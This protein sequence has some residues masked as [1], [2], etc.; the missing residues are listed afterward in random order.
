[1]TELTMILPRPRVKLWVVALAVALWLTVTCVSLS[2]ETT[3]VPA[4]RPAL[5]MVMP[6]AI[7]TVEF[8]VTV[9]E[10]ATVSPFTKEPEVKVWLVCV[11]VLVLAWLRVTWVGLSTDTTVVPAGKLPLVSVIPGNKPTVE[12]IVTTFVPTLIEPPPNVGLP[13]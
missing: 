1:M 4:G 2:T 13:L 10:P 3:K 5:V 7:P 11:V 6:G 8:I 9:A 12:L